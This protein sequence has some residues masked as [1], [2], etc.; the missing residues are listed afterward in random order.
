MNAPKITFGMIVLNGEPFLRYNLRALYPFAHQIIVV[1]GASPGAES[2]ATPDGHSADNTLG[3]LASFKQ[4]EDPEDKLLVITAEDE[5][6]P[7]GFWPGE[8]HEQSR[9]YARRACGEYLWQIDV[10]EFYKARDMEVVINRLIQSP[11]ITAVSFKMITFWG[12]FNC[13]TD[14][15]YLR[16]GENIYH[17]LFR[18]GK[19]YHYQTHRPPT[20]IGPEGNDLRDLHWVGGNEL[21]IDGIY[22]YHYSLLF[23]RQV[24]EKSQ[25]YQNAAWA[26]RDQAVNWAQQSYFRLKTPFR[27]HNVYD[28]PSWLKRYHGTHPEQIQQMIQDLATGQLEVTTR[29]T[30]DIDRLLSSS[31]YQLLSS[32]LRILTPVGL[33]LRSIIRVGKAVIRRMLSC[34][35]NFNPSKE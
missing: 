19:G 21:A 10:D 31:S 16:S 17:R 28:Y 3:T 29:Q 32:A 24:V 14:G 15:W 8:K 22:L 1:E 20:V 23:P 6:Y 33:F 18:W 2:I 11:E 30:E 27:V 7:N 26:K 5:G 4:E 9:A 12:S 34:F 25:Y 13:I 35:L